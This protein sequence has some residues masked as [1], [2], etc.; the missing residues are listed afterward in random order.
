MI[1]YRIHLLITTISTLLIS[2]IFPLITVLHL[3]GVYRQWQKDYAAYSNTGSSFHLRKRC[4]GCVPIYCQA[5]AR[6]LYLAN[7]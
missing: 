7:N 6:R 1:L 2:I 5:S 4:G 3:G